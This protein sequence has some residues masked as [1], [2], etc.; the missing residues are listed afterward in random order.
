MI[1]LDP[2]RF[3]RRVESIRDTPTEE[4]PCV[5]VVFVESPACIVPLH[6]LVCKKVAIDQ[7]TKIIYV[8]KARQSVT[9]M[10]PALPAVIQPEYNL[11]G[12]VLNVSTDV[13]GGQFTDKRRRQQFC[14]RRAHQSQ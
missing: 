11:A 14:P 9:H 2:D 12:D 10:N 3:H 13:G 1:G 4:T 5:P 6:L 8:I 7:I